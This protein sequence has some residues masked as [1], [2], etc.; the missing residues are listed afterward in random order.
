MSLPKP[1]YEDSMVTIYHG[2]CREIFPMLP[3]GLV[4][5]DPPY[6][7]GYHYDGYADDLS[8]LEYHEMLRMVC[9]PP[10]VLIHYAEDLCAIAFTLHKIPDKMVAWVYPS[11][12]AR[13]WRGVAWWGCKPDFTKDG[14]DYRN[15]T[16]KRIAERIANGE[17]ARLYDWWE[18]DQVKNI[19]AE[20]TDHPCQIPLSLMLRI[21][22]ITSA[23][24]IIDPFLGSGTTLRAAK[25]A[26]RKAIGIE[27]NERYCEIA[28]K[29]MGQEV[30]TFAP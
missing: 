6:N 3:R 29:R 18:I 11:N 19:G 10:C 30:F 8:D 16:D 21:I 4:V 24:L 17:R 28:A 2:E 20:K 22:G 15:P 25:D 13:Q 12:T 5:S 14:Q 7:V 9:P 27:R 1:Y 23:E 26:G